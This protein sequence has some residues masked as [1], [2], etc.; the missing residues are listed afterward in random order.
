MKS[1]LSLIASVFLAATA[2]ALP[3]QKAKITVSGYNWENAGELENFPVL[4]RISEARISGFYYDSCKEGGADISFALEDGTLLPHEI[5]TWNKSG[6]S[7]VWVKVP[8]LV[9]DTTSFYLRWKD[10][11]PPQNT[12]KDVWSSNYIGVWHM[13]SLNANNAVPDATGNGYD[14]ALRGE[15]E[16]TES[17]SKIGAVF[18]NG[19]NLDDNNAVKPG[20]LRVEDYESKFSGSGTAFSCSA[21]VYLPTAVT[22]ANHTLFDKKMSNGDEYN[23]RKGWWIHAWGQNSVNLKALRFFAQD[24]SNGSTWEILDESTKG[25]RITKQWMHVYFTRSEGVYRFWVDGEERGDRNSKYNQPFVAGGKPLVLMSSMY[26]FMDE[27]RLRNGGSSG[28]WIK[29]EYRTMADETFLTYEGAEANGGNDNVLIIAGSPN[30]IGTSS[31]RYGVVSDLSSGSTCELTMNEIEIPVEGTTAKYYL[32]G[33]KL[34]AVDPQTGDVS[35]TKAYNPESDFLTSYTYTHNSM[36]QFTWLWEYRDK[37]NLKNFNLLE[38]SGTSAKFSV[39]VTG[40]GYSGTPASL[41]I[42]YG[43]SSDEFL[44]EYDAGTVENIGVKEVMVPNLTPGVYYYMKAKIVGEGDSVVETA[45]IQVQMNEVEGASSPISNLVLDGSGATTLSLSGLLDLSAGASASITVLVGVS[46]EKMTSVW[47]ELS[48][49]KLTSAGI[50]RLTLNTDFEDEKYLAPGMTYYVQLLVKY[51]DGS[52]V[53]TTPTSVTMSKLTDGK[54]TYV[55]TTTNADGSGSGTISDGI[56]KLP[57]TRAKNVN[58]L[59]VNAQSGTLASTLK[60]STAP[61]AMNFTAGAIDQNNNT[62]QIVSFQQF[63]H[64]KSDWGHQL[65]PYKDRLVEFI[66]PD[67]RSIPEKG[68]FLGCTK[69]TNVIL[70]AGATLGQNNIFN[71]CYSLR[72]IY[73]RVFTTLP[74]ATFSGCSSLEGC[75]ELTDQVNTFSIF[76]GCAKIEE[77]IAPKITIVGVNAFKGCASVTNITLSSSLTSIGE[78]AFSGCSKLEGDITKFITSSL[79]SLGQKAFSGCAR[80]K[81]DLVWKSKT[82]TSLPN[83]VFSG[84]SGIKSITFKTPITSISTLSLFGLAPSSQIYFNCPAPTS[85]G[86]E[87]IMNNAPYTRVY[88][89]ED[90]DNWLTVMSSHKNNYV[91]RKENFSTTSTTSAAGKRM[92]QDTSMCE[93]VDGKLKVLDRKVIGFLYWEK[94]YGCW[95]LKAPQ[96]GFSVIV[97]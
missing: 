22:T 63:S 70:K 41:K 16:I 56:W 36:S 58:E 38:N 84:C 48:G 83:E 50:F 94:G 86:E 21:W 79:T 81:G 92:L 78:S 51:S 71:A 14:A 20:G 65:R 27:C 61:L 7:L 55:E 11:V 66:A 43:L 90:F 31:P 8:K 1:L 12:P 4:V 23:A 15:G 10:S 2:F 77:I 24:G 97:R 19:D 9:K 26:G 29:A 82:L 62:Y 35:L 49:S 37:L 60:E 34:E 45:P 25:A 96:T 53:V 88:L 5:D 85:F 95:I 13:N 17:S 3:Q 39:D 42:C 54:W 74:D 87:G 18:K 89:T 46:P 67:C 76:S 91:V 64:E 28:D 69:L 47:G 52:A 80:L 30:A 32:R 6:E 72:N 93:T 44:W 68:T 33:W 59:S 57:A 73:P 75:I 40:L